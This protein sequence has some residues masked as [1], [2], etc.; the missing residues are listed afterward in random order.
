MVERGLTDMVV[1]ADY[2]QWRSNARSFESLVV[3]SPGTFCIAAVS[4]TI[5]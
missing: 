5:L 2:L 3:F 1:A 4:K